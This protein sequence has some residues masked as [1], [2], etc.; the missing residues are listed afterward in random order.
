MPEQMA[1][2]GLV[3]D[4]KSLSAASCSAR[5]STITGACSRSRA[6]HQSEALDGLLMQAVVGQHKSGG[7]HASCTSL[8]T[9]MTTSVHF[10]M[11]SCAIEE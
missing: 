2:G 11:S 1:I 5:A 8:L 9:I 4:N 7:I 3:H 10:L 6:D